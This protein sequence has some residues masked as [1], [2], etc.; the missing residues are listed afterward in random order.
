MKFV[1]VYDGDDIQDYNKL[2]EQGICGVVTKVLQ[3]CTGRQKYYDYRYRKC[4]EVGIPIGFY[5]W[6]S[7]KSAPEKQAETFYN[8]IKAYDYDILPMLDIE[9]GGENWSSNIHPETYARIFLTRF[10][11]LSGKDMLIYSG[12]CFIEEWF[13]ADFQRNNLWWIAEYNSTCHVPANCVNYIAWQYTETGRLD[14]VNGNIDIDILH[15]PSKFYVK[16]Y[17]PGSCNISSQPIGNSYS[18]DEGT[19]AKIK[20]IQIVCNKDGAG[21]EVDGKFGPLTEQAVRK[22]P[23]ACLQHRTPNLTTWVQAR[24]GLTADG[25]FGP[26]TDREVRKWQR[27][28]GLCVDGIVGFDTIKSMC[29][30]NN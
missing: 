11:E 18:T 9:A 5:H 29:F 24:L 7:S 2:K 12:T 30:N 4:K 25:I 28:H 26:I 13:S 10:K 22:L 20:E 15:Q 16:D 8:L 27:N 14:G 6:L 17:V 3:G 21:L 23:T 1:D 19:I